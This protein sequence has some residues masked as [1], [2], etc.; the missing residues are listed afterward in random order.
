MALLDLC[1]LVA[2][3]NLRC[4]D[5]DFFSKD[6]CP[7][8]STAA[9]PGFQSTK[10]KI[11][12]SLP[13]ETFAVPKT[14]RHRVSEASVWE[15]TQ[16]SRGSSV[17]RKLEGDTDRVDKYDCG[18]YEDYIREDLYSR[19]FVDFEVFLKR[20]LHVP[21]DWA[22]RW[23][24]AIDMVKANTDFK[25]YHEDYCRLSEKSGT[26]EKDFYPVFTKMANTILGV[27][28]RDNFEGIPSERRQYYHTNHPYRLKGGVMDKKSLSPDLV[29][30]HEKRPPP[31]AKVKKTF[32][33][34]NPLHVLEVKPYDNALCDGRNMPRLV[35]DGQCA[36]Q[37]FHV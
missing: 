13:H 26:L 32:H 30:L 22:T 18:D 20:V 33:W 31:S 28:T 6:S 17:R 3:Y 34:A 37:C 11:A 10:S 19:V 27:V 36:S 4:R 29:L 14:S 15:M 24:L 25:T 2:Q 8:M 5:A 23:R 16:F 21:D 1:Q 12:S 9:P 35:V 7:A